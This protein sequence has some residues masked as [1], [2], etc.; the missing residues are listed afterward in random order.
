MPCLYGIRRNPWFSNNFTV[1]CD[2]SFAR[3]PAPPMVP[4]LIESA[5]NPSLCCR[6][7]HNESRKLFA[8]EYANCPELPR[9]PARDENIMKKSRFIERLSWCNITLPIEK[10]YTFNFYIFTSYDGQIEIGVKNSGG[11]ECLRSSTVG[12]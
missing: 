10:I 11:P 2:F 8:A 3:S 9:S 7:S 5:G 6:Y 1:L 12:T 4:Q